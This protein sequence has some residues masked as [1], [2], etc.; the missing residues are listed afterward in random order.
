MVPV[1]SEPSESKELSSK[2]R[3][4][5]FLNEREQLGVA[6]SA[7]AFGQNACAHRGLAARLA[8][9]LELCRRLALH[10]RARPSLTTATAI[11]NWVRTT[12]TGLRR[13]VL[14]ISGGRQ[15]NHDGPCTAFVL[16]SVG[17]LARTT[18]ATPQKTAPP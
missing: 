6:K 16:A 10:R 14:R 8:G 15:R 5:A 1:T 18:R 9:A 17:A 2:D 7:T 3:S 11:W 12:L 4:A 13:E